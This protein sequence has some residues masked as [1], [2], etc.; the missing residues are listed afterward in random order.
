MPTNL[1][2]I[3]AALELVA[4]HADNDPT[5]AIIEHAIAEIERLT[6]VEIAALV[7]AQEITRSGGDIAV[8]TADSPIIRAIR[9]EPITGSERQDLYSGHNNSYSR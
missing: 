7:L 1:T 8:P 5:V 6:D 2:L 4:D 3:I 9:G